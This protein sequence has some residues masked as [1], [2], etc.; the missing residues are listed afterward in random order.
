LNTKVVETL[1]ASEKRHEDAKKRQTQFYQKLQADID[2]AHHDRQKVDF[3]RFITLTS[4]NVASV[5]AEGAV[6]FVELVNTTC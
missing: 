1:K 2:K 5:K 4:T 3:A 6:Q